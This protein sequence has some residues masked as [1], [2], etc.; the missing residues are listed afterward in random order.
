MIISH[1]SA[2]LKLYFLQLFNKHDR[3]WQLWQLH[4]SFTLRMALPVLANCNA[5]LR[6]VQF[7]CQSLHWDLQLIGWEFT[8]GALHWNRSALWPWASGGP[9]FSLVYSLWNALEAMWIQEVY[10]QKHSH[11]L[12]SSRV[13]IPC[14]CV[15]VLKCGELVHLQLTEAQPNLLEIGNNQDETK[16]L[17]EEHEQLLAKLKVI[18]TVPM[19]NKNVLILKPNSC[20]YRTRQKFGHTY[21]NWI[22]ISHDL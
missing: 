13:W 12:T 14:V 4:I 16:K 2:Y 19:Q 11:T 9:S 18:S 5:I 10:V 20:M 3:L 22:Y 1:Q 15:Y 17:L 6:S 8:E 7:A 21:S